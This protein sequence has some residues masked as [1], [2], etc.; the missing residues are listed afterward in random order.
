MYSAFPFEVQIRT[1]IQDSWS[2]LDHKIKYKKS[3]PNALK[4]RINTLAALFEL[5]D[6]E[7]RAIR[8][9]TES[10]MRKAEEEPI[11]EINDDAI[12]NSPIEHNNATKQNQ[13]PPSSALDAFGFLKIAK[14]FFPH[15][16]FEPHKVDSF[17]QEICAL[18]AKITRRSFNYYMKE[19]IGRVKKY[20]ITSEQKLEIDQ[21]IPFTI[22]RH[23]LYL[24]NQN[25]FKKLLPNTA[26]TSFDL[27]IKSNPTIS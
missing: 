17:T 16:E 8:D 27:W 25:K 15:Y 21:A 5:A 23:C 12:I 9:E 4:R 20:Q 3:I 24:A 14:H 10:E 26:R 11:I 13:P 7:F 19:T 22:I 2:V 18:E 1:I 6:R